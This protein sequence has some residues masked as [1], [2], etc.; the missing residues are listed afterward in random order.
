MC[1]AWGDVWVIGWAMVSGGGGIRSF[2]ARGFKT[3]ARSDLMKKIQTCEKTTITH[4]E[5]ELK[6]PKFR[7]S[8]RIFFHL[9]T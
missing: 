6:F 3:S 2:R 4:K 9:K 1:G 8:N 7:T 5:F